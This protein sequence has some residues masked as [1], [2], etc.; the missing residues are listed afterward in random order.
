MRLLAPHEY[1]HPFCLLV[2]KIG[3]MPVVNDTVLSAEKYMI[4]IDSD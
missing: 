3:T 1:K 2:S 4:T